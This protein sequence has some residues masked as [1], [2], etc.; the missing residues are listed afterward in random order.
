MRYEQLLAREFSRLR[1]SSEDSEFLTSIPFC[2]LSAV[3]TAPGSVFSGLFL[4]RVVSHNWFHTGDARALPV[5][6][7]KC[8]T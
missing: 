5:A 8:T 7:L 4:A 3:A 6:E 2:K 1:V